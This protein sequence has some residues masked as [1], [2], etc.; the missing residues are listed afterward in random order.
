MIDNT[1]TNEPLIDGNFGNDTL[2]VNGQVTIGTELTTPTHKIN[3]LVDNNGNAIVAYLVVE[4]N[5]LGI[6]RIPLYN[7]I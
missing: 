6:R 4:I 7:S 2:R 3:G 1:N 5:N